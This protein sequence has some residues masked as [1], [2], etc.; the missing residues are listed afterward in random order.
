MIGGNIVGSLQVN[1]GVSYNI[2][3]EQ[4]VSW[5]TTHELIG[6][7]DMQGQTTNRTNYQTKLEES[8]H[9]FICDY[10]VLDKNVENKRMSIDGEIYEVVHIDDPMNLHQHLEIYLKYVG[11]QIG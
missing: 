3:G 7:L 2:I 10:V 9:V 6:F 5:E 4:E 8:T 1:Q 11:G